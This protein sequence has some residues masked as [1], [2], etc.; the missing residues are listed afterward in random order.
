MLSEESLVSGAGLTDVFGHMPGAGC[1]I[2]CD[3]VAFSWQHRFLSCLGDVGSTEDIVKSAYNDFIG[4]T[5]RIIFKGGVGG[6][7]GSERGAP[8][9]VTL[10]SLQN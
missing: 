9:K 6:M 4:N 1:W 7:S 3:G 8:G 2:G 5:V 10:N